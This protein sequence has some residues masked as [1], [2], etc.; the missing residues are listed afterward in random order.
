MFKLFN[1]L[2]ILFGIITYEVIRRPE[3]LVLDRI[4]LA[5]VDH[6]SQID[7]NSLNNSSKDAANHTV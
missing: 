5:R 1:R 2:M 6:L 4:I 7:N 3:R